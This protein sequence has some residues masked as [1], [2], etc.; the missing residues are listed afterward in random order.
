MAIAVK[1]QAAVPP[2]KHEGIITTAVETTKVFDPAK[3]PEDVVEISIQP[4]WKKDEHTETIPVSVIFT[5]VLN[6]ISALSK[7]LARLKVPHPQTG[8]Q[9][10]AD[11]LSGTRVTFVADHNKDGFVRVDKDSIRA[12]E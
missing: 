3:G 2:G 7:L 6:G 1:Q 5:P 10:Q 12:A 4:K 8:D 9:W 11:S